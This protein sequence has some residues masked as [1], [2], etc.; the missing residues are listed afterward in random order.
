[1]DYTLGDIE[2][3]TREASI[4]LRKYRPCLATLLR[5]AHWSFARKQQP[6]QLLADAT[7]ATPGVS[8]NAIT[9][10]I[11]EYSYPND[12]VRAIYVPW[13]AS[14]LT[15][16]AP[17]GNLQPPNSGLPLTSGQS[18]FTP[19]YFRPARFLL[20]RDVNFPP[21]PGQNWEDVQ[22]LSPMGQTVVL[23]NVS[24]ASLIYTSLVL[25]PSEWDSAF[26]EAFVA[27]YS[28]EIALPL[29]KDKKFGRQI[30]IDQM[31]IAER[32]VSEARAQSANETTNINSSFPD[33]INVRNRGR[34]SGYGLEGGDGGGGCF[35]GGWDSFGSLGGAVF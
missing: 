14:L 8:K 29:S 31:A 1:M 6:L 11:Y 28:A 9:P 24:N 3:G 27:Y 7:G 21:T 35:M 25:T 13:Q 33:W 23:T 26:R 32:K 30:R 15:I 10:W 17:P 22:G 4:C 20:S 16:G 19:G 5:T 2:D 12:C 18:T 34:S